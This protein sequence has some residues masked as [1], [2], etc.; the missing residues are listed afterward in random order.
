MTRPIG[1]LRSEA[2]PVTKLGKRMRREDA[3]QEPRRGAGIAEID[4]I[5]GLGEAAEPDPVDDPAP[6]RLALDAG[7]HRAQRRGG[8]QH[9]LAFQ[10]PADLGAADRECAEHQRAVRDRFVAGHGD[11][12]RQRL[13]GRAAA[14]ACGRA[15]AAG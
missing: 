14:S 8:R 6:V 10:Q 12:S 13:A 2:S 1:R 15:A 7:A 3:E 9:I 5:R 11:P 4:D